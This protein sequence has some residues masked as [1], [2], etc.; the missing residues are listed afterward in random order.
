MTRGARGFFDVD[1]RLAELSTKGNDLERVNGLVDFELFRPALEAAVPRFWNAAS[2]YGAELWSG[3]AECGAD[4]T[5]FRI[6]RPFPAGVVGLAEFVLGT[7]G[8]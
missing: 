5:V 7:L 2:P 1:E 6:L 4:A 3:I 8:R